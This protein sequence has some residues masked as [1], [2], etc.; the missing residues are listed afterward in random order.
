MAFGFV[1]EKF[2]LFLKQMS[3]IL[4]TSTTGSMFLLQKDTQLSLEYSLLVWACY[5]YCSHL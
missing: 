3:I 4:K 1:V 2:A 5:L